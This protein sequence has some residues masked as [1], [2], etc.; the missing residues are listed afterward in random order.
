MSEGRDLALK[1]LDGRCICYRCGPPWRDSIPKPER[2]D[3]MQAVSWF[4]WMALCPRCGDKRCAG[5]MNH[6]RPCAPA[7]AVSTPPA[8]AD[9]SGGLDGTGSGTEAR[10]AEDDGR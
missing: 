10:G 5:A 3:T 2:A 1:I 4:S 6:D 9:G 8:A 7:W